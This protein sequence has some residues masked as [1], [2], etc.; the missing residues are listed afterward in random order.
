MTPRSLTFVTVLAVATG[1]TGLAQ[2][3]APPQPPMGPPFDA[4]RAT[5]LD[6]ARVLAARYPESPIMSYI[7][8]V[9]WSASLRLAQLTGEEKWK[10]K[11]RR[12]M[13]PFLAR[14]KPA[15]CEPY[16]LTSLA[17]HLALCRSRR[18]R[19]QRRRGG[20][21]VEGRA[22]HPRRCAR[23]SRE[24]QAQLDRRHVHGQ[25]VAVEGS[26]ARYQANARTLCEHRWDGCSPPMRSRSNGRMGS[27][28]TRKEGPH[29][30]GRGNGFALMGL[31]EALTHLPAAWPDRARVL[32]IYR[33]HVTALLPL[34]SDDGSWRQVRR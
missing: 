28:S 21:A 8:A 17:G 29:A 22:L 13:Q 20:A 15:D 3:P 2:Q 1:L 16:Q 10:E 4:T 7:P 11:P 9:A 27:S 12:E 14:E 32:D 6:I 26:G 18:P 31:T 30:W 5:P 19:S 23:R 34:Q 33:K 25:R 24:I